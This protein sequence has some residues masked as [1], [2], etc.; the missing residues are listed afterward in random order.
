[1]A[2]DKLLIKDL[3]ARCRLGV[4]EAERAVAQPVW[5]DLELAIDA[6]KAAGRDDV[7]DA[8]DYADL[9]MMTKQLAEARSFNLME[10]LAEEV[11]LLIRRRFHAPQVTVRIKKRALPGLDYAAVEITRP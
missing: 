9:L 1:M 7:R 4:T 2:A 6:A 8:V 5:I 11:A 3:E 10:T